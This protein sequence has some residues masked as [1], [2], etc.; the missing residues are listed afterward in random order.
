MYA[1]LAQ[2]C[3]ALWDNGAREISSYFIGLSH[4]DVNSSLVC[5]QPYTFQEGKVNPSIL[6]DQEL[7]SLNGSSGE[8][9]DGDGTVSWLFALNDSEPLLTVFLQEPTVLT[10]F[11]I[12][13]SS[14]FVFGVYFIL[15]HLSCNKW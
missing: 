4:N 3:K 14:I 6:S 5:Y 7:L 13:G 9:V 15:T 10:G 8:Q 1:D 12:G 2:D 11:V